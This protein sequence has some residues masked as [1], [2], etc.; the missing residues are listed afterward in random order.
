MWLWLQNYFSHVSRM[1][2]GN[3]HHWITDQSACAWVMV[4]DFDTKEES[5]KLMEHEM[6]RSQHRQRHVAT[7]KRVCV[8]IWLLGLPCSK[9]N[10]EFIVLHVDLLAMVHEWD[11]VI[12][13][14]LEQKKGH[15][16]QG[17]S[18]SRLEVDIKRSCDSEQHRNACLFAKTIIKLTQCCR[19]FVYFMLSWCFHHVKYVSNVLY[20]LNDC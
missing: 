12:S 14:P 19:T 17:T 18:I 20:V 10:R 3:D 4:H 6:N 13:F 11:T 7:S 1:S 15:K 16:S 8:W 2:L 5:L 9:M